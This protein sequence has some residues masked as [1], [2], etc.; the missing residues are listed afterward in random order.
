[1]HLGWTHNVVTIRIEHSSCT[2]NTKMAS[3]SCKSRQ[4]Y[5]AAIA[6]QVSGDLGWPEKTG[7]FSSGWTHIDDG[8]L[9]IKTS[10]EQELMTLDSWTFQPYG[11]ARFCHYWWSMLIS[12]TLSLSHWWLRHLHIAREHL[13]TI[14]FHCCIEQSLCTSKAALLCGR[15]PS[16][17]TTTTKLQWM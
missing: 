1:M 5:L 4:C 16:I 17:P 7:V 13:I 12:W 3:W 6:L 15:T 14:A 11:W 9:R 10:S 2:T 8:E